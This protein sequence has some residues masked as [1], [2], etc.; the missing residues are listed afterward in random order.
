MEKEVGK[1]AGTG[2]GR[3]ARRSESTNRSVRP[4]S[5]RREEGK[6]LQVP[7]VASAFKPRRTPALLEDATLDCPGPRTSD[8]PFCSAWSSGPRLFFRPDSP[9]RLSRVVLE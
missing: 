9:C 8:A 6:N 7:Q 3:R 5:R 2:D 1:R 4:A